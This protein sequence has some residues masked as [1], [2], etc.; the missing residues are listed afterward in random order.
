MDLQDHP[1]HF[2][3]IW[4]QFIQWTIPLV[5][6]AYFFA[7]FWS[8]LCEIPF[9]KLEKI[10]FGQ[11]NNTPTKETIKSEAWTVE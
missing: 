10:V 11:R 5:V 6:V 1:L 2:N 8:C 4:P 3:G 9:T 7:F